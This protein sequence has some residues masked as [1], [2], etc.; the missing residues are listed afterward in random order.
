MKEPLLAVELEQRALKLLETLDC[1][2]YNCQDR[3][4]YLATVLLDY[5]N[6]GYDAC[7]L[8]KI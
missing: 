3:I 6:E 8:S 2:K 5:Y 4:G 7:I 1:R